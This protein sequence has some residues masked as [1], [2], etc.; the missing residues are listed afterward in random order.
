M[1]ARRLHQILDHLRHQRRVGSARRQRQIK[2]CCCH[3]RQFAGDHPERPHQRGLGRIAQSLVADLRR[4]I[5]DRRDVQRG[6]EPLIRH[7]LCQKEQAVEAL[8]LH[9]VE[10]T[11]AGAVAGVLGDKPE[12]CDA[13]G[14]TPLGHQRADQ[15]VIAFAPAFRRKGVAARCECGEGI[16]CRNIR[17]RMFCGLQPFAHGGGKPGVILEDQ[18]CLGREC[19]QIGIAG[20]FDLGQMRAPMRQIAPIGQV[21]AARGPG[22]LLGFARLAGGDEIGFVLKGV[23]GQRHTAAPR[24]APDLIPVD[25][26]AH[27]PHAREHRHEI[28]IVGNVVVGVTQGADDLI[29]A[30]RAMRLG[31]GA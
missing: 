10:K 30:D 18:P 2:A 11:R 5:A 12:M 25:F 19:G 13:I 6:R 28:G 8:F 1:A 27:G 21:L 24:L 3:P 22:V 9:A 17:Y 15:R 7:G 26:D 16:A 4:A 20:N 14:R 23:S 31:E 29:G